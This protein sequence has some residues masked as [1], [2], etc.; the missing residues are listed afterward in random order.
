MWV[1]LHRAYGAPGSRH[2]L[3]LLN[4]VKA[5]W[6]LPA[7]VGFAES[8]RLDEGLQLNCSVEHKPLGAKCPSFHVCESWGCFTMCRQGLSEELP[9]V[10]W[11]GSM[12][13]WVSSHHLISL[14]SH[15]G[16]RCVQNKYFFLTALSSSFLCNLSELLS[17][18]RCSN[19]SLIL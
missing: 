11:H 16:K 5:L 17:L 14:S 3:V 1:S 8:V 6:L 2:S 18:Y 19:S 7:R 10:P 4:M 9:T 12:T 15:W 13:W